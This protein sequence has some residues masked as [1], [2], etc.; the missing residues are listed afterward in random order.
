MTEPEWFRV[1]VSGYDWKPEK[2]NIESYDAEL[3]AKTYV[4]TKWEFMD[5][6]RVVEVSVEDHAGS[7]TRWSVVAHQCVSFS[8][9]QVKP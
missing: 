9:K 6:P 3:A 2:P 5:H 8:A 4:D 7:V 1:W